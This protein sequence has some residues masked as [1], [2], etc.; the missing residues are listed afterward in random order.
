MIDRKI[1]F[2]LCAVFCAIAIRA[3]PLN[4]FRQACCP[5]ISETA[6]EI[7]NLVNTESGA[8]E[9]SKSGEAVWTYSLNLADPCVLNLTEQKQILNK[10]TSGE[11]V[12]PVREITH[13]LIPAADLEFGKFS[14]HHTLEPRFMRVIMF[15]RRATIRRWR[16]D[17]STPPKDA[18]VIFD[19]AINFGKPNVDIFEVPIIFENALMHLTSLCRAK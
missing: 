14:T 16:G 9:S 1:A 10:G 7:M 11:A 8:R 3:Y 18:P 12:T 6:Q 19:A 2:A 17:S 15:T 4:A 13:Y 5:G